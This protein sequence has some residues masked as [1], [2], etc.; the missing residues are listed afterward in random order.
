MA[1]TPTSPPSAP[2]SPC[3]S[4]RTPLPAPLCTILHSHTHSHL[5]L[6]TSCTLTPPFLY[7]RRLC[8]SDGLD[9]SQ[10]PIGIPSFVALCEDAFARSLFFVRVEEHSSSAH[11]PW[12]LLAAPPTSSSAFSDDSVICLPDSLSGL[13][14]AAPG[15]ASIP[16]PES[17]LTPAGA[18]DR[19]AALLAAAAHGVAAR[20]DSAELLPHICGLNSGSSSDHGCGSGG[21]AWQAVS[22]GCRVLGGGCPIEGLLLGPLLGRGSYGRVYRGIYKGQPVAVKVCFVW[23]GVEVQVQGGNGCDGRWVAV[24]RSGWCAAAYKG[25]SWCG[26][27]C[28]VL[29]ASRSTSITCT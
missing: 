22:R 12:R 20:G 11:A 7:P 2:S 13:D 23:R 14:P 21:G 1:S 28:S 27:V 17:P 8:S 15:H 5:P 16:E 19:A 6:C 4:A 9:N 18:A 24:L 25:G 26:P 10:P 29:T 3:P